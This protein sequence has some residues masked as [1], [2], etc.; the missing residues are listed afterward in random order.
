MPS[1][2]RLDARMPGEQQHSNLKRVGI[3]TMEVEV[4]WVSQRMISQGI[5]ITGKYKMSYV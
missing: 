1:S 3:G 5:G 2:R 4:H